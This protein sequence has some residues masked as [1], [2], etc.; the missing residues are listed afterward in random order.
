M[1]QAKK[2]L[3]LIADAATQLGISVATLR[4]WADA[5]KVPSARMPSGHRRFRA[6]DIARLRREF[7]LDTDEPDVSQA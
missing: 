3:L 1:A 2:E 7:G 5:D 4:R 6:A